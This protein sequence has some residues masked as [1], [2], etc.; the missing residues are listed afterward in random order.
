MTLAERVQRNKQTNKHTHTHKTNF[1]DL[2]YVPCNVY[3]L[4]FRPTNAQYINSDVGFVKY[5]DMFRCIYTI[6][7]IILLILLIL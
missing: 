1:T 3:D 6:V 7:I 5:Y 4:L 2:M